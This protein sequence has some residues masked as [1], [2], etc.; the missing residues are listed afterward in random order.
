MRSSTIRK[1]PI[2]G[3]MLWRKDRKQ[4]AEREYMPTSDMLQ[5]HLFQTKL[6][7]DSDHRHKLRTFFGLCH[8][9]YTHD[10]KCGYPIHTLLGETVHGLGGSDEARFYHREAVFP[11]INIICPSPAAVSIERSNV[12]YI[13]V[14]NEHADNINTIKEVV[15]TLHEQIVSQQRLEYLVVVGD[16]KTYADLVK[17]KHEHSVE[18]DWMIPFPGDWHVLKNI[19]PVLMKIY[20]HAGLMEMAS[21]FI[22]EQLWH[23]YSIVQLQK[24]ARFIILAWEALLRTQIS[25][26][27]QYV[28]LH[29]ELQVNAAFINEVKE[30]LKNIT[31]LDAKHHL[32]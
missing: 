28:Q 10:D 29:P 26:F 17:L 25:S 8:A 23:P 20:W 11:D 7:K 3:T 13:G 5:Q 32:S 30:K 21:T 9:V 2:L 24:D 16:G 4:R 27:C 1:E 31:K 18:L 19:Q 6:N 14:L 22:R 15:E 12:H